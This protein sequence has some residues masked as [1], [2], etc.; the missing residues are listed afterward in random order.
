[1]RTKVQLTYDDYVRIPEDGFRHE[2]IDG[3]EFMT[4]AP[5]SDHQNVVGALNEILRGHARRKGLGRVFA[6]PIDVVLSPHD[7]VQP[8]VV[9]VSTERL[10]AVDPQGG[11]H[12]APDLVVEVLSPSTTS[13]DRGAKQSLYE[14]SGVKEYWIVDGAAQLVEIHEFGSRRRTR[15]HK[16][17]Q[18]FESAVLPGLTIAVA[19]LFA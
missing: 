5:S 4:P 9:F 3:E 13:V 11:I 8:D 1:M 2:I 17:G 7:V 16:A 15:S 14:R 12:A 6:S 18:T 10:S 19:E